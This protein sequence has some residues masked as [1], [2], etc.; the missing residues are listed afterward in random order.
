MGD[1]ERVGV[2][3]RIDVMNDMDTPIEE[4][5]LSVW[6]I[7]AIRSDLSLPQHSGGHAMA[8]L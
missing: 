6:V 5:K 1:S 8:L 4:R 7:G 2:P 3:M